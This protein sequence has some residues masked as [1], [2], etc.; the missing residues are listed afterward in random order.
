MAIPTTH[1][2]ILVRELDQQMS[3]SGCCGR[4]EGDAAF[5]S[6]DGCVF[7]ERRVMMNRF[8]EIYRAVRQTFGDSV[9][10]TV[11]DP[12]NL[13]AFFPLVI[14]DAIRFQVPLGTALRAATSTSIA[15]AI[16][17]GQL[18]FAR[19][20]PSPAEVVDLISGRLTIYR[21]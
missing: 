6:S 20:A 5:W 7:P 18:L 8:G 3:S 12:R 19:K 1:H 16:L 9:E 4:I 15:T 11:I 17:D 2:L 21:A 10:I 14:R 13:I